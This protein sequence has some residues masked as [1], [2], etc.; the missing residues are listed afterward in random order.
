MSEQG[1]SGRPLSYYKARFERLLRSD[2]GL[3]GV[4][5]GFMEHRSLDWAPCVRLGPGPR[6]PEMPAFDDEKVERAASSA[7]FAYMA[8]VSDG[9]VSAVSAAAEDASSR[10]SERLKQTIVEDLAKF[11]SEMQ[12]EVRRQ[13]AELERARRPLLEAVFDM[14]RTLV[15]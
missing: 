15:R 5:A 7:W 12:T 2:P 1:S 3:I 4:D 8:G 10:A 9:G 13:R 11:D 14:I 6:L